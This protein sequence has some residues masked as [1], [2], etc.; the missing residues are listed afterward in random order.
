MIPG[1]TAAVS[2]T[3]TNTREY[4]I[5]FDAGRICGIADRQQAAEQ[6][7]RLRLLTE[8]GVWPIFSESYGLPFRT[9]S[10]LSGYIYF[11]T[12]KNSIMQTLLQDACVENVDEF[13]FYRRDDGGLAVSF[14]VQTAQGAVKEAVRL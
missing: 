11:V 7:I 14:R 12:V 2:A 9:L 3:P 5:D 10:E 8:A 13:E 6:A 4:Y 1:I